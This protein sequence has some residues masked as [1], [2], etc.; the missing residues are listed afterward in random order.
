MR[1]SL[2]IALVMLCASIAVV[3]TIHAQPP[4][5]VALS[6]DID[7]ATLEHLLEA[8]ACETGQCLA[9]VRAAYAEGQMEIQKDTDGY[10]IS[11][12]NAEGGG[13]TVILI[14]DGI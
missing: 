8:V 6:N 4:V 2:L 1:N 7:A 14:E 10:R 9:N 13:G 12:Q 3:P 11:L 5:C